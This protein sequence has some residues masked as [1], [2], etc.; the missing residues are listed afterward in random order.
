MA[1]TSDNTSCGTPRNGSTLRHQFEQNARRLRAIGEISAALASA[2]ELEATLEVITRIT[3][4]VMGVASC[5][6]YLRDSA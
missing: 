5:S 6:I 2:W 1:G 3:S 4:E